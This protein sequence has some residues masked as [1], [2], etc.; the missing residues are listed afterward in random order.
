MAEFGEV[1]GAHTAALMAYDMPGYAHD[2]AAWW[3]VVH[4]HRAAAYLHIVTQRDIAKHRG[5]N[6]NHHTVTQRRVTL[7]GLLARATKGGPW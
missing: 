4:H 3:H 7:A 1:A 5:A 2:G 6:A